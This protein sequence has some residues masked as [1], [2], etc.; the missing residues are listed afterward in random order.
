MGPK[1]LFSEGLG[2]FRRVSGAETLPIR[3]LSRGRHPPSRP[4]PT[5]GEKTKRP[6][7][8]AR[9]HPFRLLATVSRCR[10]SL[11]CCHTLA[12]TAP[13]ACKAAPGLSVVA[14]IVS[15]AAGEKALLPEGGSSVPQGRPSLK[16]VRRGRSALRPVTPRNGTVWTTDPPAGRPGTANRPDKPA[17]GDEP[18]CDEPGVP[19]R[20][21][22][23]HSTACGRPGGRPPPRRAPAAEGRRHAGGGATQE[24]K[25]RYGAENRPRRPRAEPGGWVLPPPA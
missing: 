19:D 8:P 25:P 20:P 17:V 11:T 15:A 24:G 3:P 10:D 6:P 13:L 21:R 9:T 4:P 23:C 14:R 2:A 12:A 16:V 1:L 5:A 7:P 22:L 18:V